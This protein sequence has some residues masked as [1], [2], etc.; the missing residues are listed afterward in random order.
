MHQI[1]AHH[2]ISELNDKLAIYRGELD[3]HYYSITAIGGD[4]PGI[5]V[6]HHINFQKLP[7]HSV[8]VNG[9]SDEA[10]LAIVLDRLQFFQEKT[11]YKCPEND[12]AIEHVRSA[13]GA[14]KARQDRRKSQGIQDSLVVGDYDSIR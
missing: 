13:I 6:L 2:E 5:N 12:L 1:T 4:Q 11:E 8:G 14:C 9:I 3:N 10:L 7:V